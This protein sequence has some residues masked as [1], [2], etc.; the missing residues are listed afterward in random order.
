MKKLKDFLYDKSDILIAL[1]ILLIAATLIAWRLDVIMD[2][3]Q[4]IIDDN[5]HQ[6]EFPENQP[7]DTENEN[8]SEG[9]GESE[10][11][12]TNEDSNNE[13]N[14]SD[15]ESNQTE[16][17]PTDAPEKPLWEG[18]VLTRDVTVTVRGNSATAAVQC[19]I[20]AGLFESYSEYKDLC[21]T[22]GVADP[23]SVIAGTFTFKAGTSKA[24]VLSK[25]N[26]S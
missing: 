15:E 18:G 9:E 26:W 12:S 23:E 10:G 4:E 21:A 17:E 2:Y 24:T 5:N 20:D 1:A 3:P 13:S 14:E 16:E 22:Q 8:E 19:L 25:V 6:T 11:E 7:E